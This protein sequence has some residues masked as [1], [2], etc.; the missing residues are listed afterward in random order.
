MRFWWQQRSAVHLMTGSAI[1]ALWGWGLMWFTPTFLI[2]TY[3]LSPGEAGA[4]T[5]PIHLI[6]GGLAT[7]LTGFLVAHPAMSDPRRIMRLMGT[8][9]GL[10]TVVS[11]VIYWT[12]SLPL[13]KALFWIFIPSIYFYIGPCF[14]ILDNLAQPRMRAQFCAMTLFLANAGNLIIAPQLV[15]SLSDALAPNHIGNAESLRLA[16]L[17]LVPTGF[18]AAAHYFLATRDAL[19]DQERATG[20]RFEEPAVASARPFTPAPRS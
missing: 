15:G 9:I 18:W 7:L 12:H 14:G 19:A 8:V 1:T 10:C 3:D 2:R 16:M 4:I 6:G 20:T 13:T 5:G 11:F 17:C